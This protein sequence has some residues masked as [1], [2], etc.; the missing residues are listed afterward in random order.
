VLALLALLALLAAA[1][2][3]DDAAPPPTSMAPPPEV[4]LA[5]GPVLG[6]GPDDQTCGGSQEVD[7]YRSDASGVHP[8]VLW[9][10]GGGFVGG[11]KAG[12][13]SAYVQP[14]LDEGWDVVAANYRLTTEDGQ[15][16]FPTALLDAKQAV[17]WI[18]ANASAQGWDP[19]AVAAMGH[20]AGGNL[21]EMLAATAGDPALEPTDLPPELAAVDSS[22]IAAVALAPVSDLVEFV[23]Q[24]MFTDAV[25][26]YV[27]C[28]R[29]CDAQLLAGSVQTHV[30]ADAAP[31]LAIHGADDPWAAPSQGQLVQQAYDAAGIGDRF[32]L[33][34]VDDGPEEF[35]AHVPDLERWIG[36]VIDFLNDHL[37][38]DAE[39]G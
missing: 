15:N 16:P 3:S 34:V 25:R 10:H 20:S 7:I 27:Q 22:V 24:P 23:E 21:V 17:R 9:L 31:I 14:L 4:D 29:N 36:D 32:E 38:D 18:K 8:V 33:I 35:R 19:N 2:G 11:D 12:S 39:Q 26:R 5:Y 13:L 1:C 30:T 6:C 37:P 28:G